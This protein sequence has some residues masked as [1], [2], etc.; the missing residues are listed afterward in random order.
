MIF[1]NR[2]KKTIDSKCVLDKLNNQVHIL[3][4]D[5]IISIPVL[6]WGMNPVEGVFCILNCEEEY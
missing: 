6:T 5:S 2:N 3:T 1:K 4:Q